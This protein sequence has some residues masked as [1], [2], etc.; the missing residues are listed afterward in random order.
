MKFK[1]I[2]LFYKKKRILFKKSCL[3]ILIFDLI[4]F[5][6]RL[7][8]EYHKHYST[9]FVFKILY[10]SRQTAEFYFVCFLTTRALLRNLKTSF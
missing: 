9:V 7:C 4:I 8:A 6:C 10:Q 3:K 2:T 5:R 1:P